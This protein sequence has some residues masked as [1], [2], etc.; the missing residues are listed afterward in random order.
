M[1]APARTGDPTTSGTRG[2]GLMLVTVL[3]VALNLRLA[4]TC[5]PPL[6]ERIGDDLDLSRAWTGALTTLPVLS[7]GVFAPVAQRLAHRFGRET[8]TAAAMTV[9]LVGSALRLGGEHVPLLY[10]GT[11]CAGFGIAVGGTIAPG[12]IKEHFPDHV[13][14]VTGGYMLSMMGGA[15]VASAVSV[16]L[17]DAWD[18]WSASIGAWGLPAV[19]AVAVCWPV[20]RAA[21]ARRRASEDPPEQ[22]LPL[23][24]RHPTGW[25]VATY[26]AL[27][28]WQFYSQLAWVAPFY[29][30]R[31]WTPTRAGLLL[32]VFSAAQVVSGVL[33]PVLAHRLP[34]R[35]P[36][37][38][39]S[40]T[41]VTVGVLGLL[42]APEAAA[43]VW[44]ALLGIGL[45]SGFAMGLV[46]FN[47]YSQTPAGSARLSA[48]VF[49]VSYSIAAAGPVVLGLLR[50]VTGSYT[51]PFV[52]LLVLLVPQGAA[53]LLLH[54]RR[55]RTP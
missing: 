25:L 46:L 33:G 18:S 13:G 15:A 21:T 10:L 31:G 54:P 9:L 12:I 40:V 55:A 45:G 53:A 16:P 49:L 44:V 23:P 42:V 2:P 11:L 4:I 22:R 34:D 29:E 5:V 38:L 35:R 20:A 8:A 37:L 43:W 6:V 39:A 52:L 28:S 50:D 19:A 24:W 1:T 7:M 3:L 41:S 48:M 14:L 17:A 36:V 32:S 26:M 27:Q 47:D 30:S 51:V